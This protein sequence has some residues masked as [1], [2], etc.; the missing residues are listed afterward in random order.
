MSPKRTIIEQG[1]YPE[2]KTN[3]MKTKRKQ[4]NEAQANDDKKELD[5][6]LAEQ[7]LNRAKAREILEEYFNDQ[8]LDSERE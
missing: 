1:H 5:D 8:N 3:Q 4:K 2:M 7:W 6:F